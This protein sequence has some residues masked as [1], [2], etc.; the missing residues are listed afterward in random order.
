LETVTDKL[1]DWKE[2]SIWFSGHSL[3]VCHFVK[4]SYSDFSKKLSKPFLYEDDH[5]IKALQEYLA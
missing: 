5:K 2:S 4:N 3:V 1:K